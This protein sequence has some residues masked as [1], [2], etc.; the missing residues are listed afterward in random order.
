MS[1]QFH[2]KIR[3]EGI[4]PDRHTYI[5][6]LLKTFA[7]RKTESPSQIHAQV[8]KCGFHMENHM[9][10]SL[11][12]AYFNGG[13]CDLACKVFDEMPN[14]DVISW[15]AL[16]NGYVKNNLPMQG[17]NCFLKMRSSGVAVD[18]VTVVSVLCAAG[19]HGK[20]WFGRW[21]HGFYVE[22]GRVYRDVYVGG[23]LVDMYA[24]CGCCDDARRVSDE[25]PQR[26]TVSWSALIAGYVQCN[27]FTEALVVFQDMLFEDVE[28]NQTTLSSALTACAQLGALDQGRWIHGYID[29]YKLEVNPILGTSLIDMYAKSGCIQK[30]FLVFKKLLQK[31]IYTWSAM[32]NGL[33][34]HGHASSSLKL[35]SQMLTNGVQPN[36]V[37]LIGILSACCHGGLVDEG[38]MV[39][40]SMRHVYGFEPKMSHYG[41]M[42]D[43]LGRAGYL[44]EAL[45]L[46]Q[47]MP[48]NASSGVWGALFGAC[49]IHKNYELGEEVGKRLIKMQPNHSGRYML[50]ANLYSVCE[51]WEAVGHVRKLMKENGV[52]K[53]P[54]CSLIEVN[55]AIHE[56]ISW[57]KSHLL[58]N[59]I[60]LMV[61]CITSQLKRAGSQSNNYSLIIDEE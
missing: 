19:M 56:F 40:S 13:C 12:T 2:S 23:A 5:T 25:M 55:G 51:E 15:T 20:L 48:V 18:E 53:T 4:T 6:M 42:V 52:T 14:K 33:A 7:S 50:L 44:D 8:V 3:Q 54:G 60:Y 30:A 10:N 46:I 34:M 32:I 16:I 58:Y 31:N 45:G 21:A 1:F 36:E 39:F 37:T 28:P 26:S 43:L 59:D 9:M 57:D 38:R 35:F 24:K 49:M 27:R 11:I 22:C 17:L 41:C 61:D 29:E 47:G